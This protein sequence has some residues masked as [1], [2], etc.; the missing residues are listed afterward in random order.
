M[1]TYQSR[2]RDPLFD[3]ET[4]VTLE[5]RGRE[6]FGLFIAALGLMAAAMIASYTPEDPSWLSA[7]D[8]P[9]QNWMGRIGASIAAPLFMIVGQGSWALALAL[10]VWGIRLALHRGEGRALSCIAF[11]PIWVALCSVY[12]SGLH[13]TEGWSHSFGLGGLFGDMMMGSLLNILPVDPSVGLKIVQIL[14][15]AVIVGFGAFVLGFTRAELGSI[16]RF[17]VLGTVMAYASALTLLGR[18]ASGAVGAAQRVQAAQAA[19]RERKRG[20]AADHAAW[21][22]AQEAVPAAPRVRRAPTGYPDA[23]EHSEPPVGR[24]TEKGGFLSRMPALIKRTESMPEPELVEYPVIDHDVDQPGPDRV[25]A[26]IADAVRS[27]LRADPKPAVQPPPDPSKP[28][29]KGRGF[30][31]QPLIFK[32]APRMTDLPPEPPLTGPRSVPLPIEPPLMRAAVAAAPVALRAATAAAPAASGLANPEDYADFR[33]FDDYADDDDHADRD[34]GDIEAFDDDA[35]AVLDDDYD[36]DPQP[37][38]RQSVPIPAAKKVVQ[39]TAAS[40]F[41]RPAVRRKRR[42]RGSASRTGRRLRTAAA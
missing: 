13:E 11:A 5:R 33:D 14:M 20:E 16:A 42:S 23:A 41:C 26:R 29:T 32:P 17:L 10:L 30:G 15:G 27:R 38:A 3:T 8:A 25:R 39:P 19:R 4:A 36:P 21:L 6:L 12:A 9:V 18:G 24:P 40:P 7:T 1:A 37:V 22:A 35:D 28:L 34:A 31:P 2:G